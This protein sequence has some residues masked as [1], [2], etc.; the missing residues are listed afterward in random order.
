MFLQIDPMSAQFVTMVLFF[1]AMMW[2][3]ATF[4]WL[5]NEIILRVFVAKLC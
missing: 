2:Q 1:S 3:L 4:C 5:G